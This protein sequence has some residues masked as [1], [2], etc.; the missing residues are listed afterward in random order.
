MVYLKSHR[1]TISW[2]KCLSNGQIDFRRDVG[3]FSLFFFHDFFM[4]TYVMRCRGGGFLADNRVLVACVKARSR[5]RSPRSHR[6]S[7]RQDRS[8]SRGRS[9]QSRGRSGRSRG[10][11]GRSRGRSGWSSGRSRS[12]SR[13]SS[14][15]RKGWKPLNDEEGHL[16]YRTGD[17][18]GRCKWTTT[19]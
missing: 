5:S 4:Y 7:R 17:H 12:G 14:R 11:S 3:R 1:F 10:R 19:L 18:L 9:G 13:S 15:H 6:R 2:W 8:L 16:I